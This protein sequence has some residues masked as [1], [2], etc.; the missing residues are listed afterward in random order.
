MLGKFS[1]SHK[2]RDD[3]TTL[4]CHKMQNVCP[5]FHITWRNRKWMYCNRRITVKGQHQPT[6]HITSLMEMYLILN[7]FSNFCNN[8]NSLFRDV[9]HMC[10]PKNVVNIKCVVSLFRDVV[11]AFH[12][13]ICPH[14]CRD[15]HAC[16]ERERRRE[17]LIGFS[18]DF[19]AGLTSLMSSPMCVCVLFPD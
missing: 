4:I 19:C 7:L 9:S 13:R 18:S 1:L 2:S 3:A 6:Q 5:C 15:I 11:P 10:I 17:I 16:R 8:I 14:A 12:S